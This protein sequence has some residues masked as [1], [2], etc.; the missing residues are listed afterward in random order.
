VFHEPRS[1][2]NTAHETKIRGGLLLL[3]RKTPLPRRSVAYFYSDAHNRRELT[4]IVD[5][6]AYRYPINGYTWQTDNFN[7]I[8]DIYDNIQNDRDRPRIVCSAHHVVY[9]PQGEAHPPNVD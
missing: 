9:R 6:L 4:N 2:R 3:R 7:M 5:I 8:T 1:Q